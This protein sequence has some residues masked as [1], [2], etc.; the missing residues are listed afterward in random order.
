MQVAAIFEAAY[1]LQKEGVKVNPE[2]MI[3]I[4]MN[5]EEV[6]AI[7]YGKKIEGA[8]I[9]GIIAIEEEVRT[10][11]KVKQL[12]F[13]IGTMIELPAAALGA[14]DIAKYAQFFLIRN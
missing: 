10:S 12:D 8:S 1:T 13:K 9:K 7:I 3:P 4:V 5:T 2:I 6:K 14:G 11:L